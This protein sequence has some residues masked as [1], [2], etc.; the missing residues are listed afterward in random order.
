MSNKYNN[1]KHDPDNNTQNPP[2]NDIGEHRNGRLSPI[3]NHNPAGVGPENEYLD[4]IDD[5]H[6]D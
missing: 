1:S 3:K 5:I 6:S 4:E 2:A